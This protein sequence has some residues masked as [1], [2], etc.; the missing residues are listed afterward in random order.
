MTQSD[1]VQQQSPLSKKKSNPI[2]KI[3][4][5]LLFIV[6]TLL[7]FWLSLYGSSGYG[8]ELIQFSFLLL[9]VISL[10]HLSLQSGYNRLI[11][12]KK[13]FGLLKVSF[14]LLIIVN[15]MVWYNVYAQA[16]D[17]IGLG[18]LGFYLLMFVVAIN[19]L[20]ALLFLQHYKTS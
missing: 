12:D 19:D 8:I 5:I 17:G 15:L 7:Y 2:W 16:R 9:P 6:D 20:I 4:F 18:F 3:I 11:T 13:N 10:F 14:T 1:I